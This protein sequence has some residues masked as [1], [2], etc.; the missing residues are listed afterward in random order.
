MPESYDPS[1]Q[2]GNNWTG[3]AKKACSSKKMRDQCRSMSAMFEQREIV[4]AL[5]WL[6]TAQAR[7][8]EAFKECKENRQCKWSSKPKDGADDTYVVSYIYNLKDDDVASADAAS[9][10]SGGD[11]SVAWEIALK[12]EKVTPLDRIS[13]AAWLAIHPRGN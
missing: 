6:L 1:A 7:N 13:Q 5:E 8:S 9:K 11:R 3:R 2:R 12:D 10:S 4:E